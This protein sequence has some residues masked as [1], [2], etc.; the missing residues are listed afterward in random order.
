MLPTIDLCGLTVSRLIIGGNPFSG[1]SH[2][3]RERDEAMLDYYTT[4]RLKETLAR[5]EAAGIDTAMMRSD[6]HIHRLLREYRNDGGRL[7]WLAQVG[8][9]SEAKTML[10][11]CDAAVHYG[12]KA[13]YIH[14]AMVDHAYAQR[15]PDDLIEWLDRIRS[16]GIPAGVAGHASEAHLWV[17]SLGIADFHVV[18]FYNCGSLHVGKGDIFDEADPPRA[19]AAIRSIAKPCIGYKILAAG[20][21][22]PRRGFEFALAN[23]KPTDAVCVGMYRGD[24]DDMVETDALMVEQTLDRFSMGA[25]K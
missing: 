4:S 12:A 21:V 2:Q 19:V 24:R 11:A 14:G 20:R 13:A 16:H 3:S 9:D 17:N 8:G 10:A 1:F 5:A 25:A 22:D 7:Q 18:C 23:I 15:N 6:H